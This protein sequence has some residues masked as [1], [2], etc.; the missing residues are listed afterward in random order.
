LQ[1]PDTSQFA[2]VFLLAYFRFLDLSERKSSSL[3]LKKINTESISI[4]QTPGQF[5]F[6][7]RKLPQIIHRALTRS[8]MIS[9]QSGNGWSQI[10]DRRMISFALNFYGYMQ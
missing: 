1:I 9:K 2:P 6:I 10:N 7:V 8:L 4:H 3:P 5:Y